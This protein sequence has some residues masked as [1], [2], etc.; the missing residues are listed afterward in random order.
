MANDQTYI[1]DDPEDEFIV[2]TP[3][4]VQ[5]VLF[6]SERLEDKRPFFLQEELP[7]PALPL[8]AGGYDQK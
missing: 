6:G 5:Q 7:Y 8:R 2:P 3:E 1:F 4:L